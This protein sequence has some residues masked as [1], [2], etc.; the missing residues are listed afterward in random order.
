MIFYQKSYFIIGLF[1]ISLSVSKLLLFAGIFVGARDTL[2][3]N[4]P[5]RGGVAGLLGVLSHVTCFFQGGCIGSR[6]LGNGNKVAQN[7]LTVLSAIIYYR[8]T[9]QQRRSSLFGH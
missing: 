9:K 7:T 1:E 3:T 6:V 2:H 8:S 5:V 4:V